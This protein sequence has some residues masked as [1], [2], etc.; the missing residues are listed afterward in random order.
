MGFHQADLC[1]QFHDN[2]TGHMMR[3]ITGLSRCLWIM[4][5]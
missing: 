5:A 1:L 4:A 3:T 2:M